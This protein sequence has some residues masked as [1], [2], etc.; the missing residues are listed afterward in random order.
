MG[1]R[2]NRKYGGF[3]LLYEQNKLPH[4]QRENQLRWFRRR[5]ESRYHT[6]ASG[7]SQKGVRKYE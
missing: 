5:E 3:D 6:C 4:E 2:K 1:Q 7:G